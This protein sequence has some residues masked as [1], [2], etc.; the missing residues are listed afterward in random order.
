MRACV[1]ACVRGCVCVCVCVKSH[2]NQ[3][4]VEDNTKIC[5]SQFI[6][7][8]YR[9]TNCCV[10]SRVC[11][12]VCVCV[13]ARTHMCVSVCIHIVACVYVGGGGGD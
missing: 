9:S 5:G 6:E 8:C 2:F 11:V 10:Y 7:L 3:L 1:R 4:Y 12:C 13:C